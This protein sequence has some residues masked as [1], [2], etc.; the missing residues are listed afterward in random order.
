MT[1]VPKL[2][3]YPLSCRGCPLY[4][5]NKAQAWKH[6]ETYPTHLVKLPPNYLKT[7][8]EIEAEIEMGFAIVKF[9][10]SLRTPEKIEAIKALMK[11]T[12]RQREEEL[13]D[14]LNKRNSP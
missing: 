5:K 9:E 10:R 8:E 4:L 14:D 12:K 3:K 1:K 2:S 7:T 6:Y 13:N 11:G